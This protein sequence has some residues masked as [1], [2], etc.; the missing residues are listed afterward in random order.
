[1]NRFQCL[2]PSCEDNCCHGWRVTIDR[3]H[4]Q[5]LKGKM[6]G[7]RS[8]REE[9]RANVQRE[10]SSQKTES[11]FAEIR[12][13]HKSG[14]CPFLST[15]RL[16]SVQGRYGEKALPQVCATYPRIMGKVG[17]RFEMW[18]TLSCPELAR[19]CLLHEDAMD[20]DDLSSP[21]PPWSTVPSVMPETM[22]PYQRYLDDV[23]ATAFKLLS[24]RQY[25][26]ATR[27]FLLAYL[28]KQTAEF[29]HRGATEVDEA[30]LAA[31]I[32]QVSR[33]AAIELWNQELASMP[34]PQS[35]TAKLVTQLIR[36][37][38]K[39]TSPQF[40]TLVETT[41][42]SYKGAASVTTDD[43]GATTIAVPELWAAYEQ[44]RTH[45]LT[46]LP[47]RIDLYFENYAKNFWMREWYSH[48][49]DLLAY[50]HRLL[51]RVAVLRFLLFSQPSLLPLATSDDL[52][53]KR[54][55]LDAA[56]VAVFYQFAR[57]IEHDTTFIDLVAASLVEQ[58]VNTFAHATFLALL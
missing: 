9:F 38:L 26:I 35:L 27:L 18:G 41:L 50:A 57:A 19:Q 13:D 52:D 3:R 32:E 44:R 28:G 37:R 47:E 39:G 8:E 43:K 4:Y 21:L 45:W 34:A 1:M 46:A 48:A 25:P 2:G 30:R 58:G 31:A 51:V 16:C 36:E 40:R 10:S 29:F 6:D 20:L 23:R 12:L 54:E 7:S 24:L 17:D 5:I 49:S 22:T 14:A 15:E 53:A 42:A 33:P 55:A 56:A 11:V